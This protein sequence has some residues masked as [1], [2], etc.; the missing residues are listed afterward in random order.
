MIVSVLGVIG[1]MRAKSIPLI[2]SLILVCAYIFL[3]H[4][5]Y[6]SLLFLPLLIGG[7]ILFLKEENIPVGRYLGL[8]VVMFLV[9]V[10]Q[11]IFDDSQNVAHRVL[12]QVPQKIGAGDILISGPFGHEWQYESRVPIRRY[13]PGLLPEAQSVVCL[14]PCA[15][16]G[17]WGSI[18][19]IRQLLHH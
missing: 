5:A 1:M 3:A 13:K 6:Y 16:I 2:A 15:E 7:M 14:S 4:R 9:F 17:V 18:G 10:Q 12:S 19:E 8:M 11:C